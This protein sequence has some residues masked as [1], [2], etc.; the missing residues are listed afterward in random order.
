[1]SDHNSSIACNVNECKFHCTDH[2]YCTLERIQ[3]T[4]H[5]TEATNLEN[6]DCGS[7]VKSNH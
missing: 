1:M 5:T 4:K 3:V 2:N 7:F 6:T